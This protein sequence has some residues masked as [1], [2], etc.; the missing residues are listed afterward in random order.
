MAQAIGKFEAEAAPLLLD[1]QLE[2]FHG[3]KERVEEDLCA[4]RQLRRAIPAHQWVGD[5]TQKDRTG[6]GSRYK[7][8]KGENA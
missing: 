5:R 3:A 8:A 4:T 6:R 1:E 7:V 2:P